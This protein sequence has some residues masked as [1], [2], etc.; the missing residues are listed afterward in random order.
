VLNLLDI[1]PDSFDYDKYMMDFNLPQLVNENLEN[2]PKD[3]SRKFIP[4][5]TFGVDPNNKTPYPTEFDDL[6]RL[7]YIACARKVTTILE[8]GVGK[9]TPVFGNALLLNKEKFYDYTYKNLRRGNLYECHS[10]DDNQYWIDECNQIIPKNL[11]ENNFNNLHCSDLLVSEFCGRV[12]TYYDP[13]PNICPDLIYLDGPS[14][15]SGTGHVR[16]LSTKHQD[17]MPMAA[18][19]LAFEHFL[20]PG[21]LIIVDGRTAN[22]RFISCNLQRNW[23]YCHSADW[24]QHFF[25]LQE[26]PLGVYN[27]RMI[28][29]CL[30]KNYYERL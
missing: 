27:K 4:S 8:F 24:D 9:S 10:I 6:C 15:F 13:L 21:C 3:A 29:H 7:H 2:I 19:I 23:S 12:C 5:P 11:L 14:Q 30:G 16:G 26:E 18:D 20:Q 22:A 25:E 17:R 1:L 28:D